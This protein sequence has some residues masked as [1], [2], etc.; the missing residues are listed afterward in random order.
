[1]TYAL[2]NINTT[3]AK[4]AEALESS[5]RNLAQALRLLRDVKRMALE[6]DEQCGVQVQAAY[7]TGRAH[8]LAEIKASVADAPE[9]NI[10]EYYLPKE[11]PWPLP[12]KY[13]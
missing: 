7:A 6:L 10:V 3:I 5:P 11:W 2:E 9:R 8:L 12:G 13:H 1:M 4:A